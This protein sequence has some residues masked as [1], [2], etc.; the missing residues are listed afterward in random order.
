MTF[1]SNPNERETGIFPEHINNLNIHNKS[2]N[3]R[4]YLAKTKLQKKHFFFI[5]LPDFHWS[6]DDY[7]YTTYGE[8]KAYNNILL[9]YDLIFDELNINEFDHIF[10]F[11]DHGF[12]FNYELKS[13]P[14][15]LL[16][17]DDRTGILLFHH[18][19]GDNNL[20]KN[21]KLCS[22]TDF[23]PT[24]D[25]IIN[26]E[27]ADGIPFTSEKEKEYV[28]V[29]D[30][31]QFLPSIDLNI[32]QWAVITRDLIYIRNLETAYCINRKNKSVEQK[33]LEKYDETL[34]RETSFS[35]VLEEHKNVFRYNNF[36]HKP[37]SYMHG[38]ER[39]KIGKFLR[40]LTLQKD[41]L[42]K[43]QDRFI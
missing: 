16:L 39:N 33:L 38:G 24:I 19:K 25:F 9:C 22:I 17:N 32:E 23:Y 30:H 41:F 43:F 2:F 37:T 21:N 34:V 18:Q 13:Q 10:I 12:K 28:V 7:G 5:G 35:S 26:G 29:E 8:K 11:S 1:F 36:M 20:N 31:I 40:Y 3:L 14:K 27:C 6:L 42:N 15:H 4:D